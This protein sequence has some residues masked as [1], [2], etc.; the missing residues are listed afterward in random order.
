MWKECLSFPLR[1]NKS[2]EKSEALLNLSSIFSFASF[3]VPPACFLMM[4]WLIWLCVDAYR[5]DENSQNVMECYCSAISNLSGRDKV[6]FILAPS[7]RSCSEYRDWSQGSS[8]RPLIHLDF[9]RLCRQE[10]QQM[11]HSRDEWPK[12]AR[13]L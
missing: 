7:R 12:N 8:H 4:L 11:F 6:R 2:R 10:E 5:S 3:P 9:V 1:G 13:R